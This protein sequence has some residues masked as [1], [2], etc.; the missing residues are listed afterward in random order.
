MY[1]FD[2]PI[3]HIRYARKFKLLKFC[4]RILRKC[5]IFAKYFKGNKKSLQTFSNYKINETY[6]EGIDLL[7]NS[8]PHVC[9]LPA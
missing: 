1:I 8:E 2:L 9:K 6:P 7:D 4:L 3:H 5:W